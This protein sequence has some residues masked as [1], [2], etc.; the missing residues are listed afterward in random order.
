LWIRQRLGEY[1]CESDKKGDID[2]IKQ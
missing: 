2:T 1:C